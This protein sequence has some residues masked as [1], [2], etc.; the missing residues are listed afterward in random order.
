MKRYRVGM[1]ES[2]RS[3][4]SEPVS[5]ESVVAADKYRLGFEI[6]DSAKIV[7]GSR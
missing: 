2:L 4:L 1:K 5:V 6:H 3:D 7:I